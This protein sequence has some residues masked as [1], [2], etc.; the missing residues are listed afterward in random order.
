MA[1]P[2][3]ICYDAVPEPKMV[4]LAGTDAISGGIFE[5]SNAIDRSFTE[6]YKVDLFIPGNPVHPLTV[7]NG[8]LSLTGNDK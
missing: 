1:E 4:I 5:G 7:I 6:R 8:L 3:Q 2:L